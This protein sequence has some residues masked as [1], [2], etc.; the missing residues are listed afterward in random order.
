MSE[1]EPEND[2]EAEFVVKSDAKQES[3]VWKMMWAVAWRYLLWLPLLLPAGTVLLILF[4]AYPI[5]PPAYAIA[6]IVAG[7]WPWGLGLLAVWGTG[8]YFYKRVCSKISDG[9]Y[10]GL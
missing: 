10:S 1:D 4:F 3:S 5:V 7:E 2:P 6:L 9:W 8:M